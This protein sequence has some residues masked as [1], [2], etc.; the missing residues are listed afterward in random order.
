MIARE[1]LWLAKDISARQGRFGS[2]IHTH[3]Q[4]TGIE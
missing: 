2:H 4:S 1:V 3:S